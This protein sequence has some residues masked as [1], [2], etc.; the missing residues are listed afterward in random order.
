MPKHKNQNYPKR[1][2]DL[3][4]C[5]HQ[6]LDDTHHLYHLKIGAGKEQNHD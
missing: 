1:I 2:H 4:V 3:A 5:L 6:F